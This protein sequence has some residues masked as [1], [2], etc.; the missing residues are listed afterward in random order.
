[1]VGIPC[2]TKNDE[3]REE[4]EIHESWAKICKKYNYHYLLIKYGQ[5]SHDCKIVKND[6]KCVHVAR[7]L[8]FS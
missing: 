3:D 2:D 8:P 6:E 5:H 7:Q 1:M 4:R